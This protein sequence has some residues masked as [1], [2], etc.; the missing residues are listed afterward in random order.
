MDVGGGAMMFCQLA[1][2]ANSKVAMEKHSL[3]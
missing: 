1:I 3:M 2:L